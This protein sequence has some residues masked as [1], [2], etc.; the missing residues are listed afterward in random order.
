MNFQVQ[1]LK[2]F[3]GDKSSCIEILKSDLTVTESKL[4]LDSDI[5]NL[6]IFP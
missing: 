2:M 6:V 4:V 1:L 5:V 3:Y